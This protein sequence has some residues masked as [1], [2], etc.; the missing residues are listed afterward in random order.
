M[1]TK[2]V[3]KA[4]PKPG[5]VGSINNCP[6]AVRAGCEDGKSTVEP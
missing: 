1:G 6:S 3:L 2:T 4:E 5:F